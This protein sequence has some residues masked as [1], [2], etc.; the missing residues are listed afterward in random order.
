MVRKAKSLV[1]SGGIVST[2]N[3]IQDHGSN[4]DKKK[5]LLDFLKVI[6][7]ELKSSGHQL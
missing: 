7:F 1:K 2:P 4:D 6:I 5:I 3:P